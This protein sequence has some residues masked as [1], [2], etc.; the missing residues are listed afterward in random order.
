MRGSPK[1]RHNLHLIQNITE[2]GQENNVVDDN[3]GASYQDEGVFPCQ[4][5]SNLE[6]NGN[7]RS[8]YGEKNGK[9]N[10]KLARDPIA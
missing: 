1:S 7:L 2:N 9:S 3:R 5:T 6:D 4:N 8:F 10:E